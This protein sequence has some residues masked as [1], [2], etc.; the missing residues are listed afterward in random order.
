MESAARVSHVTLL[1][2]SLR[3]SVASTRANVM[4]HL[5]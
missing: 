3:N 4:G 2:R 1:R 5:P